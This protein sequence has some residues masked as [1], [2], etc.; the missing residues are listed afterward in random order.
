MTEKPNIDWDSF[1]NAAG[2][3][4]ANVAQTCWGQIKRKF[5][6]LA[7]PATLQTAKIPKRLLLPY[8]K[9]TSTLWSTS[10]ST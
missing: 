8:R 10:S 5:N 2:F 7:G 3:K 4:S 1:A 9:A 6:I